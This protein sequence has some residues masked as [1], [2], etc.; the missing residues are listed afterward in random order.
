[1]DEM[2]ELVKQII[3]EYDLPR[4]ITAKESIG[5]KIKKITTASLED[6]IYIIFEDNTCISPGGDWHGESFTAH[7]TDPNYLL[8]TLITDFG[9]REKSEFHDA[10][11]KYHQLR[12]KLH[13]E[14]NEKKLYKQYLQLKEKYEA[15]RDI[16]TA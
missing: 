5:K 3:E 8:E 13:K 11:I 12:K 9:Y 6:K 16:L 4:P 10:Y 1:M 14:Q 15:C 2:D 7:I